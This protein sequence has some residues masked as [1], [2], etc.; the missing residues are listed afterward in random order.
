MLDI[1][2]F[3]SNVWLAGLSMLAVLMFLPSFAASEKALPSLRINSPFAA[4]LWR[5]D[6]DESE[7]H[8]VSSSPYKAVS[9]WPLDDLPSRSTLRVPIRNEQRKRAHGV[10]ISADGKL[11]ATSVPPQA[12]S[13]GL[14]VSGTSK[15]YLLDRKSGEQLAVINEIATRPQALRFSPNGK[16][17]A[18]V[19]SDG[20]GLR[21]WQ[22]PHWKLFYSDDA[23]YGSSKSVG[24]H[25]T[26]TGKEMN[27]DREPDTTG[28]TFSKNN[29]TIWLVTSGDS[30]VRTYGLAGEKAKRL[31]FAKPADLK[32]ERPGDITFSPDGSKFLVGERRNRS[33][34]GAVHLRAAVLSS[35]NLKPV[36]KPYAISEDHLKHPAYLDRKQNADANQT[37]LEQVAW[38]KTEDDEEWIFAGGVFWCTFVNPELDIGRNNLCCRYLHCPFFSAG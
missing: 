13:N 24:D 8:I 29:S 2:K 36:R 34:E 31:N 21:V 12:T 9:V 16:F 5:L 19:L 32:L 22:A 25:C 23:N 20:C 4:T 28:L 10:A 30:G 7:R 3:A 11:V 14:P 1:G 33:L 17:L 27:V 6:I 26:K 18:A 15:V 38:V 37:S 35:E